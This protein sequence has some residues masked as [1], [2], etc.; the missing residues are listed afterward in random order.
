M[1]RR[2]SAKPRPMRGY[3]DAAMRAWHRVG[4]KLHWTLTP[5][6]WFRAG[7]D[8]AKRLRGTR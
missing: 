3:S 1:S 5:G 7:Y 8:A 2:K 4:R 6:E